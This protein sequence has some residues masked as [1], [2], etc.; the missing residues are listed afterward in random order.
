MEAVLW[1]LCSNRTKIINEGIFKMHYY[2][3]QVHLE[4]ILAIGLTA[5]FIVFVAGSLVAKSI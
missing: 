3:H 4:V 5:Y 1:R 2:K